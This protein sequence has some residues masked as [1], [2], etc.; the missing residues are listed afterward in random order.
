MATKKEI[1]E[2]L[3][4]KL[5]EEFASEDTKVS[6]T[7]RNGAD[8]VVLKKDGEEVSSV[9][10]GVFAETVKTYPSMQEV[11]VSAMKTSLAECLK[12]FDEVEE[13]DISCA[14]DA[15][16]RPG[17]MQFIDDFIDGRNHLE[18]VDEDDESFE[19]IKLEI[20]DDEDDDLDLQNVIPITIPDALLPEMA[21]AYIHKVGAVSIGFIDSNTEDMIRKEQVTDDEVFVAQAMRNIAREQ[22]KISSLAEKVSDFS[23]FESP[24]WMNDFNDIYIVEVPVTSPICYKENIMARIAEIVGGSY[25]FVPLADGM[26]LCADSNLA[27]L[28]DKVSELYLQADFKEYGFCVSHRWSFYSPEDKAAYIL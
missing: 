26:I 20:D 18:N 12:R 13:D 2:N 16:Y 10:L 8:L 23:G 7:K 28:F 6:R 14:A 21:G 25:A 5:V 4:C 27:H 17:P 22:V 9:D 15:A 19:D 1:K 24:C 11:L 3:V